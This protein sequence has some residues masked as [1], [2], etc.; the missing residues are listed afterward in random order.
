MLLKMDKLGFEPRASST[1]RRLSTEL[2]YLPS[3]IT[4]CYGCTSQIKLIQLI[5]NP[6]IG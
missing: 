1:P 4:N 3:P 2:I 6:K 5:I